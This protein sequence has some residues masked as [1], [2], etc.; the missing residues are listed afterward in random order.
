M[1]AGTDAG[2]IGEVKDCWGLTYYLLDASLVDEKA[3]GGAVSRGSIRVYDTDA[4][5]LEIYCACLAYAQ[6]RDAFVGDFNVKSIANTRFES[7][8]VCGILSTRFTL[9]YA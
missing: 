9:F 2:V 7:M 5:S 1:I 8:I 3:V 4:F 6:N